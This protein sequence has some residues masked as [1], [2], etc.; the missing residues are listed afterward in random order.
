MHYLNESAFKAYKNGGCE[1]VEIYAAKD[2]RTCEICGARHKK[3]YKIDKRPI[4]PF[5]PNCRCTYLPVTDID[6]IKKSDKNN[7]LN[8]GKS[9]IIKENNNELFRKDDNRDGYNFISDDMFNRLTIKARKNGAIIIRGTKEVEEH[10]DI[11]GAAASNIGDVLLFRK[12]VCISEVLEETYH[13]EQNLKGLNN[14]KP[15]PI[16][17]ILNEI[18]AKEYLLYNAV[19][20]KIPR[21]EI[22][23]TKKQLE[24]Y[25]VQLKSIEGSD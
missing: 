10:L 20:F 18:D 15:E 3:K 7:V 1:E 22:E 12:N 21:I 8:F 24:S 2:E 9:D 5:H 16:R 23:L 13:F 11:V 6:N 4:L 14:D 25:K 19:K 17:S